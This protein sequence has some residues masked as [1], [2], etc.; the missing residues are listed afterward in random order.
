MELSTRRI[1]ALYTWQNYYC[2]DVKSRFLQS[3]LL[4]AHE[5]H[6]LGDFMQKPLANEFN[7][8]VAPI[9]RR[10]KTKRCPFF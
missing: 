4:Q 9:S 5:V 6:Y 1:K 3:E 10:P 8:K 7:I 2:I